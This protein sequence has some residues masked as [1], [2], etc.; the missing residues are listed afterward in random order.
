MKAKKAKDDFGVVEVDL[1]DDMNVKQ[2]KSR[3][4][5]IAKKIQAMR[6]QLWPN[7]NQFNL[8]DRKIRNGYTT[9]PRTMPLIL[10]IMDDLS[11]GKPVSSTYL[12]LWCRVFDEGM[13]TITNPTE[14][15]FEVGFT[16][17]RAV[18]TW[19]SRMKIL[20]DLGFIDAKEG[21]SG[22]YNYVLIWNP[23]HIIKK[24]FEAGAVQPKYY[25][26]LVQRALDI[27]ANDL[28]DD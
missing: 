12:S 3:N 23:Y 18:N 14:I 28:D 16:G 9:L 1:E 27:G 6:D 8:W 7:A 11:N 26:A 13:V 4:K 19:V 22:P 17:Q 5:K 2:T 15:A 21:S 10:Q 20:M 24:H 25:T